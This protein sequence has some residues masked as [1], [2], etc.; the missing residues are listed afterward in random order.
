MN[1]S[2]SKNQI[3]MGKVY[4]IPLTFDFSWFVILFFLTWLLAESYFPKEYKGW[5]VGWYWIIGSATSILFFFSVILH[6]VG[7]SY[8][9]KKFHYN[10]KQIK[11]FIFGG[12]SEITEEPKKASEEFLIAS[13]GP[14]VTF[15]LSG[16]FYLLAYLTKSNIYLYALFHYLGVIN[17]I[18]AVFNLIPGF[19]LDGGRIFRAIIWG[20]KKNFQQATHIAASVGR[21]F[22]FIFIAIGFL[23]IM[24]GLWVDGLWIAFVGWF[25]ES[26][27]FS[28]VQRQEITKLL[29][30]HTV[31]DALSKAYG[32][33]PYNTTILEFVENELLMRN[34]RFFI[35]EQLGKNIGLITI[36][37]IHKVPK[38][39]WKEITVAEIM[40]PISEIKTVD[41]NLPLVEA[42]KL[43][44]EEGVNQLPIVEDDEIIGVLTRESL[45]SLLT[46]H[47]LK[48]G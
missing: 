43:M 37:D 32:L 24:A 23:E 42:L 19:P 16:I 13:A 29:S 39:K 40:K 47:F 18:L 11:L 30:G 46:Q 44:D 22:G 7:H 28:L 26:A 35:V 5:E 25:L 33:V 38:E 2:F 21:V 8:V 48:K 12:I 36:H 6:E 14:V 27:A 17:L 1:S 45:I 41:V 15:I 10:V 34:R 31:E 20:V 3:R 9:A 4:G